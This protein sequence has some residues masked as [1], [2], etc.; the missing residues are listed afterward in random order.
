MTFI[1]QPLDGKIYIAE[2]SRKGSQRL[3]W[4]VMPEKGDPSNP[5]ASGGKR[6]EPHEVPLI[7][8]TA[9]LPTIL[10]H[11]ARGVR[12]GRPP[13]MTAHQRQEAIARLASGETQADVARS[14]NVGA[15]TI[16]RLQAAA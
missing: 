1:S 6:T 4:S 2:P 7:D 11:P 16:G 3:L 5:E 8:S 10:Q 13:K 14:Y 12:F 15:T 9:S